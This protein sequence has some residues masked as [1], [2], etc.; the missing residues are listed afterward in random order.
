M[1]ITRRFIPVAICLGIVA[2]IAA[3]LPSRGLAAA[4]ADAPGVMSAA[5][6]PIELTYPQSDEQGHFVGLTEPGSTVVQG[7]IAAPE[8]P[9]VIYVNGA[10]VHPYVVEYTTP[11][12]IA[13]PYPCYRFE[14]PVVLQPTDTIIISLAPPFGARQVVFVPNT[15]ATMAYWQSLAVGPGAPYYASCRMGRA[16]YADG[17]YADA[18][19]YLRRALTIDA[20]SPWALYDLGMAYLALGRPEDALA[21]FNRAIPLYGRCPDIYYGR[22]MTYYMLRRQADAIRDLL[23]CL[24]IAPYWGEPLLALGLSYYMQE[25]YQDAARYCASAYSVWPTWPAP[26]LHARDGARFTRTATQTLST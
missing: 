17:A 16:Y 13:T 18:I 25:R 7:I 19:T 8:P 2:L 6:L 22:G 26:V 12:E 24:D 5:D 14:A 10:E 23:E 20:N 21:A 11:Y 4:A 3:G 9:D 1:S 15:L